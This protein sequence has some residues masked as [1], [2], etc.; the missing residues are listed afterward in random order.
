VIVR[1]LIGLCGAACATGAF[2]QGQ[3]FP[4]GG[5]PH[6][7][8]VDYDS[9]RI[10]QLRSAPGYQL[11]VALSPDEEIRSVALG[12]GGAWQVNA[13]KDGDRLFLKPT[14]GGS[15]TNMTVVTSV[16]V[17]NFDLT[18]LADPSADMPYTVQFRYPAPKTDPDDPQYVDVAAAT[19]R[20]LSRYR[21]SGDTILRPASV[22]DD[23][24]HTYISWPRGAPIPAIY[25]VDGT[26]REVLTNGMM[27]T[28]D[29]YVVDGAP[30]VLTFRIDD[31]LAKAVRLNTR[32]SR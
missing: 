15:T 7:Q 22:S 24:Q 6:L 11:M 23:G 21:I 2:G 30:Q 14:R 29:V 10:V 3:P 26:G 18:A 16:R 27:G 5:D 8:S 13:S 25:A 9:G 4:T 12:D 17:Y 20:R 32:K 28:D 1:S 31:K 19:S